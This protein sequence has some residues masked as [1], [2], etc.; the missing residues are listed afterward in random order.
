MGAVGDDGRVLAEL[1]I[2]AFDLDGADAVAQI[3]ADPAFRRRGREQE[4][5]V[6]N[7]LHEAAMPFALDA[8]RD[9]ARDLDVVHG[10]HHRARGAVLADAA[11]RFPRC[12]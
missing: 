3:A 10:V 4:L 9:E 6:G 1:E 11:S 7:A 8:M 2:V 5:L 12:R